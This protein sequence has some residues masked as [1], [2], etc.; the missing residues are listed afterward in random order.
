[1]DEK[2][3]EFVKKWDEM[4]KAA[5]AIEEFNYKFSIDVSSDVKLKSKREELVKGVDDGFEK[6]GFNIGEKA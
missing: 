2:I 5:T 1:M 6:N 3:K 4:L